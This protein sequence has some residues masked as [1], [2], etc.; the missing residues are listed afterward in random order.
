MAKPRVLHFNLGRFDAIVGYEKVGPATKPIRKG[1]SAVLEI[2]VEKLADLLIP[3][4]AFART[5]HAA[6]AG[7]AVMVK[8]RK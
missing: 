2:D 4:A 8:V 6:L 1:V 3:R 7:G 5:G